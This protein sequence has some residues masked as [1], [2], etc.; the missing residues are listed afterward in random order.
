[1]VIRLSS[2]QSK[3]LTGELL[4]SVSLRSSFRG[5]SACFSGDLDVAAGSK[6]VVSSQNSAYDRV[7]S[8]L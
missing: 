2:L 4:D 3:V 5:E 8:A 6:I 1:M 7:W